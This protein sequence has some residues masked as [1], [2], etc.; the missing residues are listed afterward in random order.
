MYKT[1]IEYFDLQQIARSG[2]CFRW[3][4][5]GAGTYRIPM[6]DW[7]VEVAQR[8]DEFSFSCSEEEFHGRWRAYFDLG[9]DYGSLISGI[10]PEDSFLAQAAQYGRGIRILNQDLWEVVVSFII[11]QNNNIPRIRKNIGALCAMFGQFPTAGMIAQ[12]DRD[13][14]RRLGLGYRDVYVLEAAKFF[15]KP[16]NYN[17]IVGEADCGRAMEQLMGIKGIGRKVANCICLFGLHHLQACPVDVW[18]KKM[19]EREYHGAAPVWMEGDY[20]GVYQQYAFYYM[21]GLAKD[22]R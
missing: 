4:E 22:A 21:R 10:D 16:E 12:C 2:Q 1:I 3:E 6:L 17:A 18:M 15:S 19:V 7:S 9:R 14:L 5:I 11:S 8:G 13:S 20:A